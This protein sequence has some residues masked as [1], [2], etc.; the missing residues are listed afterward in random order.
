MA[1]LIILMVQVLLA[2]AAAVLAMMAVLCVKALTWEIWVS[3]D[4]VAV[5]LGG[6]LTQGGAP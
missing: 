6:T 2:T 3:L 5:A 4:T 1:V